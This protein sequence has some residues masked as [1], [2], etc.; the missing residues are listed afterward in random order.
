[1]YQSFSTASA[2]YNTAAQ[3]RAYCE[4][5]VDRH[6]SSRTAPAREFIISHLM[7]QRAQQRTQQP[8]KKAVNFK[9][10]ALNLRLDIL[11]AEHGL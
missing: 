1:M 9:D 5:Y 6:L 8:R 7:K 2:P 3:E 4:A 11:K 10:E